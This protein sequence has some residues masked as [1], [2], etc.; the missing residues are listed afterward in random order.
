MQEFS[1]LKK[2]YQSSKEKKMVILLCLIVWVLCDI[3]DS[4]SSSSH[5]DYEERPKRTIK[6]TAKDKDGR[7]L[8]EEV[9]EEL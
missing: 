5:Y 3:C 2:K 8:I 7:V 4:V 9:T 6:R 1:D